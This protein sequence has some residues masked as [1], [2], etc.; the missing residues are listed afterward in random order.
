MS[1]KVLK[2]SQNRKLKGKQPQRLIRRKRKKK[3]RDVDDL[4]PPR[5]RSKE[6]D[7][8][9]ELDVSEKSDSQAPLVKRSPLGVRRSQT[10]DTIET[11]LIE[12]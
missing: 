2:Y 7:E 9:Y 1:K 6:G 8:S 10:T 11:T 3:L 4:P 12:P 5:I